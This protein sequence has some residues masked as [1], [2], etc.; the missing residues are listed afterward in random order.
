MTEKVYSVKDVQD[1]LH[2]SERTVFRHI[3]ESELKGF[4]TGREWRFEQGDI[5]AFI[6]L[7]RKKAEEELRRKRK[8]EPHLPSVKPGEIAA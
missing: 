7:R 8:T 6:K 5:D 3:R 1:M 4:K 2:I